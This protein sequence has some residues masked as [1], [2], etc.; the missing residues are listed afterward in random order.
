[1]S[2]NIRFVEFSKADTNSARF[3]RFKKGEKGPAYRV[4][5]H[6]VSEQGYNLDDLLHE[7]KNWDVNQELERR[8]TEIACEILQSVGQE[9]QG[10]LSMKLEDRVKPLTKY[11]GSK[12]LK[13]GEQYQTVREE[14]S[15]LF[16]KVNECVKENYDQNLVNRSLRQ[17]RKELQLTQLVSL[18]T[19]KHI[20]SDNVDL[21]EIINAYDNAKKVLIE[22]LKDPTNHEDFSSYIELI[23]ELE[24]YL[25]QINEFLSPAGPAK[26]SQQNFV[27]D[28]FKNYFN[29]QSLK[30]DSKFAIDQINIHLLNAQLRR[31]AA[32]LYYETAAVQISEFR[33][34][35]DEFQARLSTSD[36]QNTEKNQEIIALKKSLDEAKQSLKKL[37]EQVGTD[38]TAADEKVEVLQEKITGLSQKFELLKETV[39]GL[40]QEDEEMSFAGESPRS[41][42][43]S[44]DDVG[45]ED[46]SDYHEQEA[47]I[48]ESERAGTPGIGVETSSRA[49]SP[50]GSDAERALAEVSS[51]SEEEDD[52]IAVHRELSAGAS[53]E[54][55][56]D[57]QALSDVVSG[58]SS[59][60]RFLPNFDKTLKGA[61]GD[62]SSGKK[63]PLSEIKQR[64][65]SAEAI[66]LQ[67][68]QDQD[69]LKHI[70]TI[71][72]KHSDFFRVA[73]QADW[74]TMK[75]LLTQDLNEKRNLP[76]VKIFERVDELLKEG[77][78]VE[79]ILKAMEFETSKLKSLEDSLEDESVEEYVKEAFLPIKRKIQALN[80]QWQ[81]AKRAI[82]S[83]A[84]AADPKDSIGRSGLEGIIS[85]AIRVNYE[86]SS[87]DQ[88]QAVQ[89]LS[90]KIIRAF[91]YKRAGGLKEPESETPGSEKQYSF[92]LYEEKAESNRPYSLLEVL[93]DPGLL[94]K[95]RQIRSSLSKT[96]NVALAMHRYQLLQASLF[97]NK[98]FRRLPNFKVLMQALKEDLENPYS[99]LMD[100]IEGKTAWFKKRTQAQK[101]GPLSKQEAE[102]Q[103]FEL[104]L[105][106]LKEADDRQAIDFNIPESFDKV[107]RNYAN[108]DAK[109]TGEF[110]HNRGDGFEFQDDQWIYKRD[111]YQYKVD[112]QAHLTG[113]KE[114][115]SNFVEND[116]TLKD[117]DGFLFYLEGDELKPVQLNFVKTD[118]QYTSQPFSFL[119]DEELEGFFD[120]KK[121]LQEG[122]ELPK[123][124]D[125]Q[126]FNAAIAK[127][128]SF[129]FKFSTKPE[130]ERKRLKHRAEKLY[131]LS[132]AEMQKMQKQYNLDP[133][134]LPKKFMDGDFK[135]LSCSEDQA[136]E[137]LYHEHRLHFAQKI[138]NKLDQASV[139]Q[140]TVLQMAGEFDQ[141]YDKDLNVIRNDLAF[142]QEDAFLEAKKLIW[143]YQAI[144]GNTLR[145]EQVEVIKDAFS[146]GDGLNYVCA[147]RT[148]FGKTE[149]QLL[150]AAKALCEDKKLCFS[151]NTS[152]LG[153]LEKRIL[154]MAKRLGKKTQRLAELINEP[155]MI[156]AYLND[157]SAILLMSMDQMI[158]LKLQA[159]RQAKE[160]EA[161]SQSQSFFRREASNDYQKL[162]D[163]ILQLQHSMDEIELQLKGSSSEDANLDM[164]TGLKYRTV[165]DKLLVREQ[166]FQAIKGKKMVFSATLSE[167][168]KRFLGL[169]STPGLDS[170]IKDAI[171]Q[172]RIVK[173]LEMADHENFEDLEK[174]SKVS[175]LK[176]ILDV[177]ANP[178]LDTRLEDK[179]YNEAKKALA[180]KAYG[181]GRE[182]P[183]VCALKEA[184]RLEDFKYEKGNW[185]K[186]S[187]ENNLN[188]FRYMSEDE[189]VGVDLPELNE[190]RGRVALVLR[191]GPPEWS[192][193]IQA[194]GRMRCMLD[195]QALSVYSLHA[196]EKNPSLAI[197]KAALD[198]E[199]Q[200]KEKHFKEAI[201]RRL[202]AL[203]ASIVDQANPVR[204]PNEAAV[205]VDVKPLSF[206]FEKQD[207][208][209]LADFYQ[210]LNKETKDSLDKGN[211]FS[212]QFDDIQ[213]KKKNIKD[214]RASIGP[215]VDILRVKLIKHRESAGDPTLLN[216]MIEKLGR[217][218]NLGQF[219]TGVGSYALNTNC[220]NDLLTE[221][222]QSK[223]DGKSL[224]LITREA[225]F[226]IKMDEQ[227]NHDEKKRF[228][229]YLEQKASEYQDLQ[230]ANSDFAWQQFREN[231]IQRF[232]GLLEEK[233]LYRGSIEKRKQKAKEYFEKFFPEFNSLAEKQ[234]GEREVAA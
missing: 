110:L 138:M 62:R 149:L 216:K 134:D 33:K 49:S 170:V 83:Y 70:S 220:V 191:G 97:Q 16:S 233:E 234:K 44:P 15:A 203:F 88:A 23:R 137:Y 225:R 198:K 46:E 159:E 222:L 193:L 130:K 218:V 73:I 214:S 114:D 201:Q 19:F 42:S 13:E 79:Q 155:K 184:G 102:K 22:K 188:V 59:S 85:E 145:Q 128:K 192:N 228:F 139:D 24:G 29:P 168:E 153:A 54:D 129:K 4:Y 177:G 187:L 65:L 196:K 51:D 152:N 199:E 219:K 171:S 179:A 5:L 48:D 55:S 95:L 221:M 43:S 190:A 68:T 210:V 131:D 72:Q 147:M 126:A 92:D 140:Q 132:L 66:K 69:C 116:I 93:Q 232:A 45:S 12:D 172:E 98:P 150:F 28:F 94:A 77:A 89:S 76:D 63:L 57:G 32:N 112:P 108:R 182:R 161:Q 151:T 160:T 109:K 213:Q 41:V 223:S 206:Y 34:K 11:Q 175:D 99:Y 136:R 121:M 21:M 47:S 166:V 40:L 106:H 195:G 197:V 143:V 90:P 122:L 202:P 178:L 115:E 39:Y 103:R 53:S 8:L 169:D 180:L 164:F 217:K 18:D 52:E 96:G 156:P 38:A 211:T 208:K 183:L 127:D 30:S 135:G 200:E 100:E 37:K 176:V 209:V 185:I 25:L 215:L 186:A 189:G 212:E 119:A 194:M 75:S 173:A 67:R 26:R 81:R 154:P 146:K 204:A 104:A 107:A 123:G 111:G 162:Y 101:E 61:S 9:D 227:F 148:G 6:K 163:S 82:D 71:M 87:E 64:G 181:S 31:F 144:S 125:I 142:E 229:A 78:S 84:R 231:A 27:D 117:A 158:Q 165:E 74:E 91:L 205:Q 113:C 60:P 133:K 141:V 226:E 14:L 17:S 120:T 10:F 124:F 167:L 56:D 157:P 3:M 86:E 35:I 207:E 7:D 58:P 36:Q 118:S 80:E 174:L 2:N 50:S 20:G 224:G 230:A 1:M 105:S